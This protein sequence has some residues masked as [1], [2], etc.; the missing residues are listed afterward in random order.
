MTWK[1]T[2]D[3]LYSMLP[4]YQRTGKSAYKKDLTNTLALLEVLDNP[5]TK[6]KTIHIAGTNGKGTSAHGIAAVMQTAGYTTGLYTSPHLKNFTERIRINGKEMDQASIIDFV[7]RMKPHIV[8]INPSF[9]EVTVAMAFWFFSEAQIDIAVIETGL[10]GRLDSTNVIKPEVSLITN[11]GMDHTDLLG[12]TLEKIA[13]EKAGIIKSDTPVVIGQYQEEI[14]H[15]FKNR[16]DELNAKLILPE[17]KA[18]DPTLPYYKSMNMSGISGVVEVLR[19][20]NWRITHNDFQNGM[21]NMERITGFKGRFQILKKAPLIIADVSHNV[22]GLSL[23]FHRIEQIRKGRLYLIFGTVRDKKLTPIFNL[24]PLDSINIWTQSRVPRA[25]PVQELESIAKENA[26]EGPG[27]IN[28]NDALESAE[29]QAEKSD[30][31]LITG[32]TF[33]VADL[34]IL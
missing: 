17:N 19:R 23:L 24:F 3:F 4:M 2:L 6:F 21:E 13:V 1:E 32:S 9:F 11:I 33:V 31:I 10:G 20:M 14:F 22:E 8:R 18:M 5:H 30:I 16:A 27:F 29:L 28:V 15:V 26:L 34:D 7:E 25:L 12:D